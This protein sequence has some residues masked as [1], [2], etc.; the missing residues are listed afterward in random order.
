LLLGA[1]ILALYPDWFDRPL[2]KAI[3]SLTGDRQVADALAVG[4]AYPTLQGVIVVSLLWCCWFSGVKAESRAKLMGGAFAAAV[5]GFIAHILK[6]M[7]PTSPR[8]IFDP[9]VGLHPPSV[10][11]DINTL[12]ATSF[13]NSHTFPSERATLFAGL[14]IAILLVRPRLGLI[15]LGCTLAA[16]ISRIYL[17][18]HNLDD[19]VG[20]F[21]LA[22]AAVWL[23]QM[24]W[25]SQLGLRF[26]RW[27]S[28]SA[29]I[30]YTCAFL[31]CYQIA[32]GFQDLRDL[33]R[34]FLR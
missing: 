16:E 19:I 3:N 33:A 7:L 29:A 2:A 30:F 32:S 28:A 6:R 12:R 24:R 9:A 34:P 14:A 26:V 31:A 27:E 23:A 21:S 22:A 5:A 18:L 25:G 11:G 13:P 15:A 8:P 1:T 4:L 10:L 20:S 17:G